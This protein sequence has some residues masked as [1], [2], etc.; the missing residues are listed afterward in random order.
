MQFVRYSTTKQG[1]AQGRRATMSIPAVFLAAAALLMSNSPAAAQEDEDATALAKKVQNPIADMVSI[2]F[3]SNTNFRIGP[4][5]G[6]Q[7]ILNVQPVIPVSLNEN[8]NVITRTIIPFVWMPS[9]Q[10]G[11]S[12]PFG[13]GTVQFSAF[14]SPKQPIGGW[15]LGGGPVVQ[16][17]TS[18]S[19]TLG[20]NV[21]G[22]G[23]TAVAVRNDGPWVYGAIINNVTSFGGSGL[24]GTRYNNFLVQPFVNYNF[25]GGW[26][27]G[28]APQIT[29]NWLATG[30]K[31]WTIPVGGQ[32]GRVFKIGPLPVNLSGGAYYNA[33]RA[34]YAPTWQVR[35]QLTF[36]F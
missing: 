24:R 30:D 8:W 20:S 3:Q 9:M 16:I 28:S 4:R 13:T 15:L 6:T 34:P 14:F 18:S 27:V 29:A 25:N 35:T 2:P 12:V 26:Y 1:A 31:A 21:W 32:A 19:T 11:R 10:P 36:M 5:H 33:D 17:P 22:G 23:P 7:E